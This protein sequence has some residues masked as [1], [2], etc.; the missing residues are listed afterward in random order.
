MTISLINPYKV[1]TNNL[2][3]SNLQKLKHQI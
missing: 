1:E 2:Y 3:K